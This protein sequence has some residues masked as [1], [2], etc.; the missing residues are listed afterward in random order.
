MELKD[1]EAIQAACKR[2]GLPVPVQGKANLF[3]GEFEG[4]FLQLPDCCYPAVID[5]ATIAPISVHSAD[6][7]PTL[8][9]PR[10]PLQMVH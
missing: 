2:R 3:S 5:A 8:R 9:L 1:R 10:R 7:S 6:L 4:L